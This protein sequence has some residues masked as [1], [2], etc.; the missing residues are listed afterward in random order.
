MWYELFEIDLTEN[1]GRSF[2]I[3]VRSQQQ[4]PFL[5]LSHR[6]ISNFTCILQAAAQSEEK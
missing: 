6:K 5:L 3:R 2:K 1:F 4:T